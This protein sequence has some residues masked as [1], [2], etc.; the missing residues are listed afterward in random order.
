MEQVLLFATK[1]GKGRVGKEI[2]G[3]ARDR[4]HRRDRK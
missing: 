2:A 4:R 3:I 1:D